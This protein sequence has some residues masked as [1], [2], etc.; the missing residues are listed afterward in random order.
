VFGLPY[1]VAGLAG[2]VTGFGLRALA[3]LRDWSLPPFAARTG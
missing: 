3:I 2:F 1:T